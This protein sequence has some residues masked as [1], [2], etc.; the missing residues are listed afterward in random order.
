MQSMTTPSG[1]S[2]AIR[3]SRPDRLKTKAPPLPAEL[4]PF[5]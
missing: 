3:R 4:S 5:F 2:R 1:R